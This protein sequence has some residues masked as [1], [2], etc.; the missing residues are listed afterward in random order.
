MELWALL[1][2]IILNKL[3]LKCNIYDLLNGNIIKVIYY[4]SNLLYYWLKFIL[5]N[6]KNEANLLII[7]M[8]SHLKSKETLII[9]KFFY[10]LWYTS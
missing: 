5:E 1:I 2:K 6:L 4:Q 7:L 3:M 8:S 10:Q 9:F